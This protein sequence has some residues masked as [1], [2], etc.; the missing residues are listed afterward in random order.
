MLDIICTIGDPPSPG[1]L[2]TLKEVLIRYKQQLQKLSTMQEEINKRYVI[3]YY[4]QYGLNTFVL[5]SIK[6]M[7]KTIK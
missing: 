5:V 1:R 3:V 7:L 2:A 4:A 6:N